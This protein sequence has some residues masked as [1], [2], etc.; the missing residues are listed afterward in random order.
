MGKGL[1][2]K[3]ILQITVTLFFVMSIFGA[4]VVYQQREK[5]N[6]DLEKKEQDIINPLSYI[7]G[8]LLFDL[9]QER[10]VTVLK[11]YLAAQDMLSMK[12]IE[13]ENVMYHLGKMSMNEAEIVNFLDEQVTPPIYERIRTHSI[14]LQYN[15]ESLGMLEVTF[16]RKMVREEIQRV[17]IGIGLS[18]LIVVLVESLLITTLLRR[19][20]TNPLRVLTRIA[21]QIAEGNFHIQ[22]PLRNSYDEI[23]MFT[24]AFK[25]MISYI[26]TITHIASRISNGD[27]QHII[28]PKSA[29]DILGKAFQEMSDYLRNM[30]D[31]ATEIA[32][33]DLRREI[34]PKTEHDSLGIAFQ[35]MKR[36]RQS[37]GLVIEES[38]QLRTAS[39]SL[40]GISGKMASI[41]EQTSQQVHSVSSNNQ[42]MNEHVNEIST[43]I[44]EFAASIREIARNSV[45]VKEIVTSAVSMSKKA[46]TTILELEQHSQEIGQISKV[47]TAITQQTN[48]L[49]LNATIESARAGDSGMGFA[50]VAREVKELSREIANSAGDIT[51]KIDTIQHS[52]ASAVDVIAQIGEITEQVYEIATAIV[53]SVD[54]QVAVADEIVLNVN[55]VAHGSDQIMGTMQEVTAVVHESSLQAVA[56]QHAAEA[57]GQL[58]NDLQQ[59]VSVFKI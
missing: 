9:D 54:E 11:S 15:G 18:F 36:L 3:L 46:N 26:Q 17:I 10:I 55:N 12:I 2:T 29:N 47:I 16:S 6:A 22:L 35:N 24:L 41:A 37:V 48:L 40:T 59:A 23:G 44:E 42:Q 50:V 8:N 27:L 25:A 58:A 32:N 1:G 7:L 20:M 39:E 30:A 51:R 21:H 28:T 45:H 49:A 57:L 19:N 14:P 4:W 13:D 38:E 56:V 52:T 33:G 43:A 34:Q 53:V 5:Y 31:V